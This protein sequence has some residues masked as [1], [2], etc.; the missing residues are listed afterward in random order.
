MYDTITKKLEIEISG[1]TTVGWWI[2]IKHTASF[3]E[4]WIFKVIFHFWTTVIGRIWI[5]FPFSFLGA[6]VFFL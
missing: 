3:E 2:W 5:F 1:K 6:L 4:K